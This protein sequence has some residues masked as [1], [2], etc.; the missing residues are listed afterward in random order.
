MKKIIALIAAIAM[1]FS[2]SVVASAAS[3][4][5]LK[6]P[7]NPSAPTIVETVTPSG[8]EVND[9]FVTSYGNRLTLNNAQK[10]TFELGYNSIISAPS[11]SNL[12]AGLS[13][14]ANKLNIGL[15][16]LAIGD[17]FFAGYENETE[18]KPVKMRLASGN[19]KNFV[20]LMHFVNG[21]W[22]I[23][24]GVT[25]DKNGHLTVSTDLTGP[26]AV[27]VNKEAAVSDGTTTSPQ[28]GDTANAFVLTVVMLGAAFVAVKSFK[29][30][31]G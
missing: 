17:L 25:V 11:V 21:E 13:S 28:T 1:V 9:F 20:A 10:M 8:D 23:V 7:T 26:F 14:I 19:F 30:V 29:K 24:D 2:L 15:G 3:D 5:F 16:N 4:D 6:S 18:A 27:V 12:N 22:S 31:N